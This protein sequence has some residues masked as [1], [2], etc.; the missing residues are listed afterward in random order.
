MKFRP[1]RPSVHQLKGHCVKSLIQVICNQRTNVQKL[2][3]NYEMDIILLSYFL[4][5]AV[6]AS[7]LVTM[8]NRGLIDH[9]GRQRLAPPL[10]H[11]LKLRVMGL[12]Y[13]CIDD[14]SFG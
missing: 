8:N 3:S 4:Q 13:A 6:T 1:T 5:T 11:V 9:N 10:L 14:G 12:P 2:I 7:A